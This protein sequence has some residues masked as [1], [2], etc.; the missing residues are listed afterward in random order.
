M[1]KTGWL[2]ETGTMGKTGWLGDT[3]TMGGKRLGEMASPFFI[4]ILSLNTPW[5]FPL[6]VNGSEEK[7]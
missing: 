4:V 1:G 7:L 3:G 6:N 2:G 5:L